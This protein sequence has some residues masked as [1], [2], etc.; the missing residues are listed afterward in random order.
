MGKSL[1]YIRL[2]YLY[3]LLFLPMLA[4]PQGACAAQDLRDTPA[5]V[6]VAANRATDSVASQSV[7]VAPP[8]LAMSGL[9][10]LIEPNRMVDLATSVSGIVQAVNVDRG[11]IIK[12]GQV[13][14]QLESEVERAN[15]AHS[16]ARVEF[17]SKKYQRMQ[18]LYKEQMVSAQQMEEAKTEND[19]AVAELRKATEMLHQRTVSSPF[20]GVV[21]ERYASPGE[22]VEGKKVIKVAQI[23]PLRVEVI[24][25]IAMLGEFKM[26]AKMQV[27]PEG[28]Y[29]GPFE[30]RVHLIDRVIDAQ[31]GTFRV[32]LTLPNPKHQIS[33]GVRCKARLI[34]PKPVKAEPQAPKGKVTEM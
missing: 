23:N 12:A 9:D 22:L 17:S 34:K 10:C 13:L 6:P 8:S 4:L 31:S 3:A 27:V 11:D 25:P 15:V 5:H 2:L 29:A 21:V 24:A 30:A 26:G 19:L 18:G 33:A 1:I 20:N 14:A 32:R 28:P 16:A 7:S